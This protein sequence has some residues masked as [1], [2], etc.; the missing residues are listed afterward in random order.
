M[1]KIVVLFIICP[2]LAL[3]QNKAMLKAVEKYNNLEYIEAIKIFE[4]LVKKG[5]NSIEVLEKLAN[6]NY[7]NASYLE[8]NKWFE[9]LKEVS[10]QLSAENTF[11]FAHTLRV[12]GKLTE[13]DK[14]LS[15][16]KTSFPNQIRTKLLSNPLNTTT[17][18]VVSNIENLSINSA[19]SDYGVFLKGDTIVFSS[20]REQF[21]S[22]KKSLRTGEPFT[23]LLKTV[24]TANGALTKPVLYAMASYSIY[25]DATPAFSNDG[26]TM[27]HTQNTLLSKSKYKLLNDGFKLQKSQWVNGKWESVAVIAF[28]QKDSVKIAHP[29]ISPDGKFLYFASDMPGTLGDSD[30]F[31]I[32]VNADGSFGE[33]THLKNNVNTEGR[34]TFPFVTANNILLFASNGHPGFG[35]LDLYSLDLNDPNAKVISLG[36]TI[37][38]AYDDFAI[39]TNKELTKGYFTSNR[40]GGKGSDDIYSFDLKIIEEDSIELQKLKQEQIVKIEIKGAIKDIA[41]SESLENVNLVLVDKDNKEIG[42]TKSDNKGNYSFGNIDPFLDYTIK[43]KKFDKVM[44]EIAVKTTDKTTEST[45]AV[46]KNEVIPKVDI[47]KVTTAIGTDIALALKIDQIYFDTNKYDIRPDAILDLD[48]LVAY[49]KLNKTVKIEI[50]SHTDSRGSSIQN[51]FLSQ[52]RAQATLNYIVSEGIDAS[53]LIAVGYG[54]SKLVNGC[55][56]GVACSKE[57]HQQNRRSTFIIQKF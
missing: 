37:N 36:S 45:I 57:Q 38:S 29:A 3:A 20:A 15:L 28:S 42:T 40:L 8:A 43:V 34:E 44:S 24:K 21:I 5:D 30:L 27:Y 6:A 1:K 18:F 55:K 49:M 16:F 13:A 31:K 10:P 26:K 25:N 39:A 23:N 48:L 54:E 19:F 51:M 9:K 7:Q 53:R 52:K 2:L 32:E 11:R 4:S 12:S 14:Q 17:N 47:T 22:D 46:N 35:G 33:I 41:T 50:G 56:D